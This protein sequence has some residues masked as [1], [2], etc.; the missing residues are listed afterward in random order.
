M[1]RLFKI[2]LV[3]VVLFA[4]APFADAQI[5]EH[6][7]PVN[8]IYVEGATGDP[9]PVPFPSI[10]EADVMW[11]K[12]IWREID[13]RQKINQP[14]YYPVISHHNW[15]NF[16]THVLEGLQQGE[17]VAYEVN[18]TDEFITPLNYN[19]F[20]EKQRDTSYQTL[21]RPY[22]PYDEYDTIIIS[23]FDPQRVMRLRLKEDWYFD[24]QRSQLMVRIIA[25]CPVQMVERDGEEFPQPLFW[26][27][28]AQARPYL[29]KALQFNRRNSAEHRSYDDIFWKRMFDSYIY[30]EENHYDRNINSYAQG[31]DALEEAARI[32]NDLFDMEQGL[33]NY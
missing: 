26:V 1:K 20:M 17:F 8:G 19:Q 5:T 21:Q 12:R 14:F 4:V 24:R 27:P 16:I 2:A 31:V 9:L 33:W 6:E 7:G 23:D 18:N 28:Y 15:K 25:F 22:P 13:F 3:A 30:K 10:R 32:K 11:K 29:V